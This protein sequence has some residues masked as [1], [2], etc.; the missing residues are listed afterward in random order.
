MDATV[1]QLDFLHARVHAL[2]KCHMTVM[3]RY[4]RVSGAQESVLL[5]SQVFDGAK[6]RQETGVLKGVC[7]HNYIHNIRDIQL[8]IACNG[9]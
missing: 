8:E 1:L 9:D 5:E 3:D 2:Q 6:V 7:L 4:L